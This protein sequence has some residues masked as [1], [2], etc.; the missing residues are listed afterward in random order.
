MIKELGFLVLLA[1]VVTLGRCSTDERCYFVY[2]TNDNETCLLMNA[3]IT[4]S[5]EYNQTLNDHICNDTLSTPI[6]Y[7][8]LDVTKSM[9][10][11]NSSSIKA[12]FTW[13][14]EEEFM[15][16]FQLSTSKHNQWEVDR[17]TLSVDISDVPDF[18]PCKKG[19]VEGY[20]DGS[21]QLFGH[22]DYNK[23]YLCN[24]RH[25]DMTMNRNGN[26]N[27]SNLYKMS[28][29]IE[30]LQIQAFKFTNNDYDNEGSHCYQDH[31]VDH[32]F[33]PIVIGSTI[34]GLV[35]VVLIAYIVGRL[36]NRKNTKAEYEPLN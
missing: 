33:V 21:P 27:A 12:V 5:L 17:I 28:M 26:Y 20:V 15:I 16:A 34:G 1:A 2:E 7:T 31:V 9:S 3:T 11:C 6:N 23:Y 36:R 35:L 24:K 19:S 32:K 30:D 13:G 25:F 22:V 29:T 8:R 4:M 14:D 18:T 10:Y